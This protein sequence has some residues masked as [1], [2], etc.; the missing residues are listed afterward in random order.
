LLVLLLRLVLLRRGL[1]LLRRGLVL[2]LV[3]H[4]GRGRSCWGLESREA[5][6]TPQLRLSLLLLLLLLWR[7][8][9]LRLLRSPVRSLRQGQGRLLI[10]ASPRVVTRRADGNLR[11]TAEGCVANVDRHLEL[12]HDQPSLLRALPAHLILLWDRLPHELG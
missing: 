4:R 1:V 12:T 2:V 9:C 7:R 5:V 6:E 3:Q 11:H 10:L 8:I